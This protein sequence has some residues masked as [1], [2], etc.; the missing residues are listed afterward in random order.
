[1]LRVFIANETDFSLAG[2]T[3]KMRRSKRIGRVL[4]APFFAIF[5]G[6]F[7]GGVLAQSPHPMNPPAIPSS[8]TTLRPA[9]ESILTKGSFSLSNSSWTALGP[10]SLSTGGSPASNFYNSG[11]ITGIAADPTNANTIYIAA[12]GGGVWKTTDGGATWNP[13]TDTQ[14]TLAMGAIA[15]APSN[16]LK[17]YAGTGD[18]RLSR[19]S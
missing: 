1:M 8:A 4:T 9:P 7:T 16:N 11:R 12:A 19:K 2:A 15:I 14:A 6:V 18:T 10:A 17:I 3:K 5:V 13:L